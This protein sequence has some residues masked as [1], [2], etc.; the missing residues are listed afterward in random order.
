MP[1]V[2]KRETLSQLWKSRTYAGTEGRGIT[3][4]PYEV[5]RLRDIGHKDGI[6]EVSSEI[7]GY[8]KAVG[9]TA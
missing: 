5:S 8:A 7:A 6:S 1:S 2:A 9:V 3:H 4:V